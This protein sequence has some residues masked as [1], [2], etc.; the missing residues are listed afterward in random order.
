M[1]GDPSRAPQLKR[2]PTPQAPRQG[3]RPRAAV[4]IQW[5]ELQ[6][7]VGR[8]RVLDR[9][10]HGPR[11]RDRSPE[12]GAHLLLLH[13]APSALERADEAGSAS[14]GLAEPS[15]GSRLDSPE[16]GGH[17]GIEPNGVLPYIERAC[18]AQLLESHPGTGEYQ[19]RLEA[20]T[21]MDVNRELPAGVRSGAVGRTPEVDEQPARPA[22]RAGTEV[23]GPSALHEFGDRRDPEQS[24]ALGRID[25]RFR[26][27][28]EPTVG[29]TGVPKPTEE[30]RIEKVLV[31]GQSPPLRSRQSRRFLSLPGMAGAMV[32][33]ARDIMDPHVLT[34]RSTENA[35]AC[36]RT[37]ASERKGY[38]V[39]L[40]PDG[41]VVGI[42]TEWDF[43]EKVLAAGKE[44]V[45]NAGPQ[46]P[47]RQRFAR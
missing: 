43:L 29:P 21:Q 34:V 44:T 5:K 28:A 8:R 11:E 35:L 39:V 23:R 40:R 20:V 10:V 13:P 26:E 45:D 17:L 18:I 30:V 15:R 32:L 14:P 24:R 16:D 12:L 1:A 37:L 9:V 3:H 46:P 7:V 42:V 6:P 47:Y 25:P 19:A 22:L 41:A 36:A 4:K 38:A 33:L 31:L 27:A 2:L